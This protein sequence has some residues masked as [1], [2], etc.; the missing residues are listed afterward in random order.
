MSFKLRGHTLDDIRC[1][2]KLISQANTI[3]RIEVDVGHREVTLRVLACLLNTCVQR[4][5]L[6]L[7]IAESNRISWNAS[8]LERGPFIF[9]FN[10][11]NSTTPTLQ[12]IE[13]VKTS[14]KDVLLSALNALSP[15]ICC[16]STK[17]KSPQISSSTCCRTAAQ[18]V[19]REPRFDIP[20]PRVA[21]RLTGLWMEGDSLL[22]ATTYPWTRDI[23]NAAPLTHLSITQSTL[24]L[25]D[26]S[27]ILSSITI[28]TLTYLAIGQVAV[29]FPDLL[30]FFNR[31]PS[32]R[33]INL[34]DND[35]IGTVSF[36]TATP[37]TKS[38]LL[39]KLNTLVAT[40]EYIH[41]FIFHQKD[42]YFQVLN[43]YDLRPFP[44]KHDQN[45]RE[46][47]FHAIF[48]LLASNP[49]T[50]LS[51]TLS[52]MSLNTLVKWLLDT[53]GRTGLR[54]LPRIRNLVLVGESYSG[55]LIEDRVL[56]LLET[57]TLV[58][59]IPL[60]GERVLLDRLFHTVCPDLQRIEFKEILTYSY[61]DWSMII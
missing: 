39:P 8:E 43:A 53:S 15:K 29:A 25:F 47:R 54:K 27:Q 4:P 11:S 21:P 34:S 23:I 5:D 16:K 24:T 41:P 22:R 6:H 48:E 50:H 13:P 49:R 26:W 40:P 14:W 3:S 9:K 19:P 61:N 44:E 12:Q 30:D 35:L 18:V 60:Q 38:K 55:R 31:H 1:F 2:R 10:N 46:R 33:I 32:L 51:I 20:R 42:G 17:N 56:G 52:R 45:I 36:P 57:Q 58:I 37:L 7:R 59:D 28:P